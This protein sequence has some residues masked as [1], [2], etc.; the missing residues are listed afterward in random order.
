[1]SA[2]E[3]SGADIRERGIIA[4][5]LYVL[6][7][8]EKKQL[9]LLF[10]AVV[11]M[12]VLDTLG[13]ASIVP[14]LA[15][16]SDP[17]AIEENALLGWAY[18]TF[19][20]ASKESFFFAVGLGV[21]AMLTIGNA[22]NAV[23]T[24]ALLRFSWMRNHSLG[25]RLLETYARRPYAFFLTTNTSALSQKVLSEVQQVVS[26]LIVQFLQLAARVVVIAFILA[27]LLVIDP[28]MAVGVGVVFGGLYGS[29]FWSVRKK[30]RVLGQ[31][32][33]EAN[34]LRFKLA[35]EM[36]TGIK[37]VK[38]AGLE[39]LFLQ[40]F[41][42]PSAEMARTMASANVI[43]QLP[44]FALETVAFSGVL[45]MVLYLLWQGKP[46]N[47]VLPVLGLYAFASYRMLPGLQAIFTGLATVRS[48]L[49]ALDSL[50][51]D[52][53]IEAEAE[54]PLRQV[55]PLPFERSIALENVT[56]RYPTGERPVLRDL[57]LEIRKG[58]WNAFVGPTGSGKSTLVDLILGLLEPDAG[59]VLVD[60]QPIIGTDMRRWQRNAGY[61]PQ[62]IFLADDTV[63]RNIAFG[64]EDEQIDEARLRRAA[65]VAQIADFVERE[66]PQ[67]FETKVGERGIRLSGGQRQRIG[68]ARALYREPRLLV[69]DEATSALDGATEERFFEALRR[70]FRECTV[71][72]IAH[73]L[74]TTRDFDCIHVLEAGAIVESGTFRELVERNEHFSSVKTR[75]VP[76]T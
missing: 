5:L 46:L 49:P 57:S 33:V 35:G 19:H 71:I 69:L 63:A 75:A 50:L 26:G 39:K 52:M 73:R 18:T 2:Q 3:R 60:G 1:M 45:L 38:L 72:S 54:K 62:Q 13:I 37:E 10:P 76:P 20:F 74:T 11:L 8:R 16:L 4:K 40:R 65:E 61:V 32:R 30:L 44:R 7:E 31:R 14:F 34:R 17:S 9:T 15:L 6:S 48:N 66:L 58:E 22:F 70:E 25:M 67:G 56:F 21:L 68:I 64:D 47:D 51:E 28:A 41:A 29:V 36:L 55:E 23:T 59:R 12:A 43:G 53:D 42:A 24:W 27:A